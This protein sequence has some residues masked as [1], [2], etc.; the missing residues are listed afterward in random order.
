[1]RPDSK[2]IVFWVLHVLTEKT[3][4]LGRK[5]NFFLGKRWFWCEKT[6]FFLEKWFWAE[7]QFVPRKKMVWAER[8]FF[9]QKK[10]GKRRFWEGKPFFR[11]ENQITLSLD[12]GRIVSNRCFPRKKLV[13]LPK[14]IF[15]LGKSWFFTPKPSFPLEKVG[16]SAQNHLFPRE[17]KKNNL[18]GV[19]PHS[20]SKDGLGK[21]GF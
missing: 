14:T 3:M 7:N 11:R 8:Q 2:K 6:N 9:P 15:F 18:L 13:F 19:L 20:V 10:L 12:F 16:L 4:I 17:D 5:T 21:V 1:M